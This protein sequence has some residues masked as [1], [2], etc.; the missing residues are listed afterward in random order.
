MPPSKEI[1]GV[2]GLGY[3]GLP[4]ACAFAK[5]SA[6]LGFDINERRVTELS[7]FRD[8]SGE[9]S[10]TDLKRKTLQFS[11]DPRKLRKCTALIVAVP[12]PVDEAKIPDL[13]P[14]KGAAAIVGRNLTRGSVVVFESTVYPGVTEEICLPIIEKESGLKLSEG[15]FDL[16]YSPERINP[17]DHEHTLDK[18][19]KVVSGHSLKA[20]QRVAL[21]YER[22][23]LAGVHRAPNIRTAEAAKVIENIQRD[24]NIALMNE[25]ALI[26]E[27]LNIRTRDVLDAAATKWNFHRYHPGL[28]GGHCIGVDPYYLT[29]RALEV[30]I[31]PQVIL[32]GRSVN[33]AMGRHV[34]ESTLKL[35][36]RA[37]KTPVKSRV[38]MLGL[39]FKEN[40]KDTR[41]SRVVDTIRYLRD[42]GVEVIGHDP[43]LGH[44]VE[45]EDQKVRNLPLSSVK[46]V[47]CVIL[48]NKHREF[49]SLSLRKLKQLMKK[50]LL[51]DLKGMFQPAEASKLGFEYVSL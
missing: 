50:P 36:I 48:V 3:V 38:L 28:V 7:R 42:F 23:A 8:S 1:I 29:H 12:T 37:G 46:Q 51:V 31:H 10:P 19:I 21:L 43:N 20:T 2:V 40:V 35:L 18:I 45:L 22:V 47:D 49:A 15:D 27:R 4:L 26:F 17:G 13:K 11:S 9:I 6:V 24:L 30:G 33:D 44:N 32:A 25:L 41:N 16:G 34:G 14:L 5:S 39:T